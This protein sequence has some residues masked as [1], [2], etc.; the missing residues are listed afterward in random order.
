MEL[1]SKLTLVLCQFSKQFG[2]LLAFCY[3]IRIGFCCVFVCHFMLLLYQRSLILAYYL[4]T[5]EFSLLVNRI[6]NCYIC[7]QHERKQEACHAVY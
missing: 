6:Y 7:C 5:S 2:M 1:R 4:G 3:S